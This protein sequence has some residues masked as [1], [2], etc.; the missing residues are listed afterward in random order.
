MTTDNGLRLRP[1]EADR[2]GVDRRVDGHWSHHGDTWV[3]RPVLSG[4]R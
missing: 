2:V 4:T 1:A 3:L